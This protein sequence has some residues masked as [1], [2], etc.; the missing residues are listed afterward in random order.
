[1]QNL[2]WILLLQKKLGGIVTVDHYVKDPVQLKKDIDFIA[3]KSHAKV[4][5]GEFGAPIPDI[6]GNMTEQQQADW[7]Q[8][9]LSLLSNDKNLIGLN[10]WVGE[11][12]STAIWNENGQP[13][14]AYGIIAKYFK[15]QI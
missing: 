9:A 12:G 11:G 6:T 2:L 15:N 7:I 14:R 1:M 10:Y 8:K 13:K 5:L 4:I 3:K